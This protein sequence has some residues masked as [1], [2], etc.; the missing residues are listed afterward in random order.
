MKYKL[1]PLILLYGCTTSFAQ[2]GIGTENPTAALDIKSNNSTSTTKAI[3][4]EDS[5]NKNIFSLYNN[6]NINFNGALNVHN[7]AKPDSKDPGER[8]QYLVSTGPNTPPKWKTFEFYEENPNLI[9]TIFEISRGYTDTDLAL[10][11]YNQV[12]YPTAVSSINITSDPNLGI[13]NSSTSEFVIKKRGLYIVSSA[14][15]AYTGENNRTPI[16][17]LYLN[18]TYIHTQGSSSYCTDNNATFCRPSPI[19][20]AANDLKTYK[21]YLTERVALILNVGD[22]I[23]QKINYNTG[24]GYTYQIMNANLNIKYIDIFNTRLN[25]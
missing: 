4:I 10:N 11:T 25:P 8:Y 2:V 3:N 14:I 17:A 19:P 6:G 20:D 13:W 15:T 5:D 16:G 9:M 24:S 7:E 12:K 21:G 18:D 22:R 1:Y 23:Y